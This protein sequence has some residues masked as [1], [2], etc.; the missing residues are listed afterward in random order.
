MADGLLWRAGMTA[1]SIA[2]RSISEISSERKSA[3]A[4]RASLF[5]DLQPQERKEIVAGAVGVEYARR[6]AIFQ[7]GDP[8]RSVI[9]LTEGS[10]K[11]MQF[12]RNGTEVILR[13]SGPGEFVGKIGPC[14][15]ERHGSRAQALRASKALVWGVAEFEALAQRFPTLRRNCSRLLCRQ[16]DD[17][18]ERFRLIS[19]ERVSTRLSHQL[20]RLLGQVGH[21]TDG[22]MEISLSR[23]ELAQ[24]IGT[25]LFTVSRLLSEWDQ[26]GFV[27][28]R[29]EAVS[30]RNLQA[31]RELAEG[32]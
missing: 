29:R 7:E 32:E 14:S 12:G 20:I 23:E 15:R 1:R 4:E 31:L 5:T 18:E 26:L 28:A 13:L 10:V 6:E 30:I 17:L 19:T 9:L 22:V 2:S 3:P 24:L 25:T 11:N 21:E 16:M 8:V 27:S